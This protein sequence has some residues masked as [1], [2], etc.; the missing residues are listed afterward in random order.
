MGDW[1]E[2]MGIAS[3]DGNTI[4]GGMAVSAGNPKIGSI[5]SKT[6]TGFQFDSTTKFTWCSDLAGTN[7]FSCIIKDFRI[8]Y[9]QLGTARYMLGGLDCMHFVHVIDLILSSQAYW[10]L[11][12][13]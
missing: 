4:R 1:V 8:L 10:G 9:G 2:F 11:Q 3:L 5:Y 12:T 13:R 6:Y 7:R